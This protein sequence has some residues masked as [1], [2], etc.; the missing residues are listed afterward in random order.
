MQ[1]SINSDLDGINAAR[2]ICYCIRAS[3]AQVLCISYVL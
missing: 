2:R 3:E 1:A